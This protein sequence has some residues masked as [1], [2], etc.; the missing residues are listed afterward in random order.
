MG[1]LIQSFKVCRASK[2]GDM[3]VDGST[4][5]TS[6]EKEVAQGDYQTS[7][8]RHNVYSFFFLG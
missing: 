3:T 2:E 4:S 7:K 6:I 5:P 8:P 1:R